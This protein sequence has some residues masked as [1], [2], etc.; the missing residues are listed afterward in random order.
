VFAPILED[1]AKGYQATVGLLRYVSSERLVLLGFAESALAIRIQMTTGQRLPFLLGAD[2]RCVAAVLDLP[3]EVLAAEFRKLRWQ[4]PPTFEEYLDDVKQA[5]ARGWAIDDG[6]VMSA[7]TTIAAP[8][9]GNDKRIVYTVNATVF[10]SQ[11]TEKTLLKIATALKSA[12]RE[13]TA[14]LKI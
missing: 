13:V 7:I 6:N 1:V 14:A 10:H 12:A 8:I 2:G 4:N 11:H 9:I 3:L 5:K